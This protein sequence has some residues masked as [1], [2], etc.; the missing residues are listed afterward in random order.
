MLIHGIINDIIF[1]MPYK[2]PGKK[3]TNHSRY[4]KEVWYPKNRKKHIGYV[5]NVKRKI[6]LFI[7]NY[8]KNGVCCDCGILGDK[9]P[10]IMDFDHLRDKK[11]NISEF[12]N[13]TSGFNKVKQEIKKCELVCANCHRIRTVKR[14][15]SA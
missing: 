12:K 10:E 14:K 15:M 8:K 3:R 5:D 2:D 4:M 7:W 13:H 1:M 9:H 6:S 11:F